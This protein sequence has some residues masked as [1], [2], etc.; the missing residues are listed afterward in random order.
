M[1]FA[2]TVDVVCDLFP[3]GEPGRCN[4]SYK[5]ACKVKPQIIYALHTGFEKTGAFGKTA[6][7]DFMS[8]AHWEFTQVTGFPDGEPTAHGM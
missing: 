3:A 1:Q 2:A 7:C 6:G 4:I 5:K 8:E